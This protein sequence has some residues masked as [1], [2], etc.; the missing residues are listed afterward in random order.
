[1]FGNL[2]KKLAALAE[3]ITQKAEAAPEER[4]QEIE[5]IK[6]AAEAKPAEKPI[7]AAKEET[8][9]AEPEA[10]PA[11]VEAKEPEAK[12][13]EAKPAE[14][15]QARQA[16]PEKPQAEQKPAG[17]MSR[18]GASLKERLAALKKKAKGETEEKTAAQEIPAKQEEETK[19]KPIEE[20]PRKETKALAEEKPKE[21]ELI[22]PK[23]AKEPEPVLE[24]E[25]KEPERRPE[26]I[27]EEKPA[28]AEKPLEAK[29]KMQGIFDLQ[30]TP[31]KQPEKKGLLERIFGGKREEPQK[32][33]EESRTFGQR[34]I[35][36]I[37][38]ATIS[39]NDLEEIVS[40][41]QIALLENDVAL[42]VAEKMCADIKKELSG[43]RVKRTEIE[44]AIR[45]A[46]KDSLQDVLSKGGKTIDLVEEIK[47]A[48]KPYKIVFV[49]INGTGKTTTIAKLAY[50]LKEQGLEPVVA[51]SDTFRAASIE[52]LEQHTNKLGV[53]LIKHKYGAD[54]TAVAFDAVEHAKAK[55]KA[56]VL[57][58]TA[59]RMQTNTNLMDELKKII[60]VIK[61]NLVIFV[62]DSL[63]GNDAI[64]QARTFNEARVDAIILTKADADAKGGACL[65]I[66]YE[67]GK[68]ILYL[69]TGQNYSDLTKFT[70]EWFIEKVAD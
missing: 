17:E 6:Q 67:I 43:K 28:P 11:D 18:K 49:G 50:L 57:I 36:A 4:A 51:A 23:P 16:E 3:K 55:G 5:K 69:G 52:Q 38:E 7:E 15:E 40:D 41:F 56:A 47:S 2:K 19:A 63:T 9:Q 39:E 42:D 54:A 37:T 22:K 14:L 29:V 59:G 30:A 32:A 44:P 10:K 31:A 24:E 8:K 33:E 45:R 65:S 21:P 58:D 12:P 48:E 66:A 53:K 25:L 20:K 13:E 35:G 61:P 70:P 64:E 60:R 26:P 62:G 34:I 1:M 46:I 68:P 27:A